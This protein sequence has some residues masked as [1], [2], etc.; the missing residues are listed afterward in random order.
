MTD[1]DGRVG[2]SA[3]QRIIE[4]AEIECHMARKELR[5]AQLVTD[6]GLPRR[7]IM[8]LQE[9]ILNY[10][11][12][13]KPLREEEPLEGWWEDVE[14]SE[15]WT[16]PTT[17]TQKVAAGN[18]YEGVRVVEKEVEVEKPVTGLDTLQVL[19]NAV[20]EDDV[21]VTDGRGRRTETKRSVTLLD[22]EILYDIAATLDDA[23]AKLG[24]KPSV[25]ETLPHDEI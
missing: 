3:R 5:Q 23:V 13:L 6:G 7:R 20:T 25:D 11:Q 19:E 2:K 24:L 15:H 14:L 21:E 9:A 16:A 17:E 4:D 10:Y 12:A 8:K 18:V 1:Q 22:P